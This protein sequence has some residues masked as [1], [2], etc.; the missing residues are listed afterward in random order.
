MPNKLKTSFFTELLKKFRQVHQSRYDYSKA[1][2]KGVAKKIEIICSNHGSFWQTP[3]NHQLGQG[4]PLCSNNQKKDI[5]TVIKE[6]EAVH[7][8]KYSYANAVYLGTDEPLEIICP[9]HGSFWQ[10]PTNHKR[11][12]G[13]QQCGYDR[14]KTNQE[15]YLKRFREIHGSRYEYLP[16]KRIS[17]STFIKIKCP[18]H[19][20]FEQR[21]DHHLEGQGC[22]KCNIN[23]YKKYLPPQ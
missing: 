23:Q 5:V 16:E 7:S 11:G 6:F 17:R 15:T 10:K 9:Q 12:R 22:P 19:D 20:W 3:K 21:A 1:V 2:Y 18:E 4:C 8:E 13:C 14:M